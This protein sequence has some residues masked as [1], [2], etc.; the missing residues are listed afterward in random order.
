VHTILFD[1][2]GTLLLSGAV[3]RDVFVRTFERVCGRPAAGGRFSFAGLTDRGIFHRLLD[4]G[5]TPAATQETGTE[6]AALFAR[7]AAE[8]PLALDEIY[9]TAA[10]P[11]LLPGVAELL[12]SLHGRGDVALALATGNLR[13]SAY[14]KLRRF[15]LDAYFP[16]G[17]FG[18]D[19]VDRWRVFDAAIQAARRHYGSG[20]PAMRPW[21]I[22]DTRQDVDAARKLGLRALA[23]ATGPA[24]A[25]DL[26]GAD[27]VL[28]DLSDTT[29]V[30]DALFAE[31]PV[32]S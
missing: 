8:Y 29:A 27:V 17:G 2:D 6:A 24:G 25:V 5:R 15:G 4:G 9:P 26:I 1:I 23:V 14:V 10:G 12:A 19:H 22:G 32:V 7:F 31:P 20:V 21:V 13:A 18:D 30:L 16:A 3:V 11:Y 28:E